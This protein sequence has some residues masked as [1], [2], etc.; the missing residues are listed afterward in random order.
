MNPVA[1]QA[2]LVELH[3]GRLPDRGARLKVSKVGGALG[4]AEFADAGADRPGRDQN[5]LPPT[6]ANA[7]ELV[8][9]RL[10]AVAV[11]PA[12][13][14]G[15]DVGPDL[16]D[17]GVSLGNDIPANGALPAPGQKVKIVAD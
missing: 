16:D 17:D 10:N 14:I 8:R 11:E 15:E 7:V 3:E 6:R 5:D 13:R 4:E 12:G 1:R 9:E 2:F